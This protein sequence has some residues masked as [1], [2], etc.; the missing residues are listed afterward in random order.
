MKRLILSQE[1]NGMTF[2]VTG[3]FDNYKRKEIEDRIRVERWKYI[4]L[5]F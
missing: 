4:N 1:Y 2:V 3:V 5:S